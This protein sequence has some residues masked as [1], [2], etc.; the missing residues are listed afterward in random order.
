MR[1]IGEMGSRKA[2]ESK[3]G[4]MAVDIKVFTTKITNMA[5][6]NSLS[7]MDPM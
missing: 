6:A 5:K 4:V 7:K 1:E 2:K 3:N